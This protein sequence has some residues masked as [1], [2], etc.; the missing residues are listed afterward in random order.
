MALFFMTE[1]KKMT[2]SR[3]SYNYENKCDCSDDD[4]CGCTYPNNMPHDFDRHCQPNQEQECVKTVSREKIE[5]KTPNA[6]YKKDSVC[7]C[8]PRECDCS[9]S[10]EEKSK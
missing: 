5:I 3:Y 7:I 10:S 8:S 4:N 9:V 1:E 2:E 6:H